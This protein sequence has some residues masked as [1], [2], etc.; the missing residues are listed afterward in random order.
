MTAGEAQAVAQR[1]HE[2]FSAHAVA[3]FELTSTAQQRFIERDWHPIQEQATRRLDLYPRAVGEVA[4]EF[5]ESAREDWIAVRSAYATIAANSPNT[6]LARTFFNSVTRRIF[7]TTGVDETTEFVDG[8]TLVPDRID[9]SMIYEHS[10]TGSARELLREVLATHDVGARYA[11]ADRDAT[12]AGLLADHWLRNQRRGPIERAQT[13]RSLFYRNKGCYIIGR[14]RIED[15]WQPLVLALTHGERGIE[16]D[17]VLMEEND[18]SVLFSFARSYFQVVTQQPIQIIAFLRSV[19]PLKPLAELYI[20][21]GCHKQG[22]AELF[23]SLEAHLLRSEGRFESAAVDRGMVMLVFG[24]PGYDLVFKVIRDRF[25]YPKSVTRRDVLRSYELVFRH[26]RVGR[27]VDAQE[28]EQLRFPR[29]RFSPDLLAELLAEAGSTIE[30]DGETVTF[31]HLY[32]ER[33]VI[34]LNLYLR[35]TDRDSARRALL[36]YGHAIKEL[37]AANIFPGDFLLKN[38]GVT[39][40]GRVVFY[41][42]DELCRLSDCRFR[43]LPAS[44]HD[45]DELS[46]EPWFGVRENDIFPEEFH[47]FLGLPRELRSTFE[48]HHGDLFRVGFWTDLQALHRAGEVVDIFPY[49]SRRRLRPKGL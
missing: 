35:Q 18:I 12:L 23:R 37:A 44:R 31:G 4:R 43:E 27:L 39:R 9:D 11:R 26:D 2:A 20:A 13:L 7:D 48:T 1:I 32:T 29:E 3:F 41:D 10:A 16:V 21:L 46:D 45:E 40:H 14:L 34:P 15:S 6:E 8:E 25:A 33:R 47:R 19:M 28:F 17:A 49:P 24:L 38:F 5:A 22:K 42:Y 36:D 30:D